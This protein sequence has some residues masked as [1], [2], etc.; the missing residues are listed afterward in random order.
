MSIVTRATKLR[1]NVD[2]HEDRAVAI[3]VPGLTGIRAKLPAEKA[4]A[5]AVRPQQMAEVAREQIEI[6]RQKPYLA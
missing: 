6:G 3:G 2:D 1:H 5:E 4:R